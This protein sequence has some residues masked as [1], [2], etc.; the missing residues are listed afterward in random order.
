MDIWDVNESSR[1]VGKLDGVE[2]TVRR[3]MDPNA[4]AQTVNVVFVAKD[5]GRASAMRDRFANDGNVRIIHPD[6]NFDT[7][8]QAPLVRRVS[9]GTIRITPGEQ[10]GRG[11][12]SGAS[13]AP[14]SVSK[15]SAGGKFL[16][17]A[18]IF[19]ELSA[20]YQFARD[21]NTIGNGGCVPSTVGDCEAPREV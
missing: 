21:W 5:F 20:L 15:G 8:R 12:V 14:R 13:A 9:G 6:S 18:G 7:M 2:S 3:K 4:K 10:I 16:N 11:G 19:G 1:A 17:G